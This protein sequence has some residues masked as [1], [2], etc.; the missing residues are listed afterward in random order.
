MVR[1]QMR[2]RIHKS[3]SASDRKHAISKEIN[4]VVY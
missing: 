1:S 4:V 3:R 2:K